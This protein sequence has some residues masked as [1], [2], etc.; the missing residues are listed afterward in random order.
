[1]KFK[2]Q[3]SIVDYILDKYEQ[4]DIFA[5]YLDINSSVIQ[6]CIDNKHKKINNPLR[7]DNNPSLGF[8]YNIHGKLI[9]RDFASSFY[10]G[11]CFHVAGIRL[12]M[13]CNIPK[14][15]VDICNNIDTYVNKGIQGKGKIILL[16][17]HI[18]IRDVSI[19][20]I[21]PTYRE[22]NNYDI[23]YFNKFEISPEQVIKHFTPAETVINTINDYVVED[24][25]YDRRDPCY[26]IKLGYINHIF[27]YKLYFPK[28][29][30]GKKPRFRTNYTLNIEDI[31]LI[32]S[33]KNLI[34]QKSLKDELC[35]Q[36]FLSYANITNTDIIR[37][38]SESV[39]L[40][41]TEINVLKSRYTNIL[42]MFDNDAQGN[43]ASTTYLEK[44]SFI[45]IYI[46]DLLKLSFHEMKSIVE[47]DRYDL[48]IPKNISDFREMYGKD[49]TSILIQT[50][51]KMYL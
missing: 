42:T 37:I 20:I 2:V 45:P 29:R 6:E 49:K 36:N 46:T 12:G 40:T 39:I 15:F 27:R 44:Y 47:T 35:L 1:M 28:R 4:V 8:Q 14:H 32:G 22:I 5:H 38:S 24:Y 7:V 25:I 19:N 26:V 3:T 17:D 51:N 34:I 9:M 11:D 50:L 31:A 23:R 43:S 21:E 41:Q 30:T 10:T 16:E 33:N 13:N 48:R 18:K